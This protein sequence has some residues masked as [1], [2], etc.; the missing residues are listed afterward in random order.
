MVQEGLGGIVGYGGLI[1]RAVDYVPVCG[2]LGSQRDDVDEGTDCQPAIGE[3]QNTTD[4]TA[5]Y[6]LPVFI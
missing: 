5:M 2:V 4:V 1:Y 3:Y 6:M